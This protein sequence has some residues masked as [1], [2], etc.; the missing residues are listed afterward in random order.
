VSVRGAVFDL[1]GTLVDNMALHAQAFAAFMSR[2]A[3]PPLD[4]GGRARL[5]GK[6]NAD[7]FPDLFGRAL[8]IEELRAYAEEKES[9]YRELSR[10]RLSPLAG[11]ERLLEHLV[12]RGIPFAV[13][14]SGPA[15]NVRHTL[16][17]TGLAARL[18]VVV[19]GDQVPR[20]KPHPDIFLAAAER[21]GVGPSECLAFED[22]PMG[23]AAARAAGMTCVAIT[24]SFSAEAFQTAGVVPDALV[25]DFDAF[26]AGPGR[27][28]LGLDP[29]AEVSP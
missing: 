2:H 10:G 8:P 4:A 26:L 24:T 14:T 28:L 13:A 27:R 21:L 17:E 1:D 25:A 16:A 12:A 20:G 5:D 23:V 7:I 19:R 22:S 9:L 29:A 6:R 18:A 15:E 11:L 3:L